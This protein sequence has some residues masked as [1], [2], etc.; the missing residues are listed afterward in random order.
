VPFS[1]SPHPSYA[2]INAVIHHP[3]DPA[4]AAAHM[5]RFL[6]LAPVMCIK[7]FMS[8]WFLGAP[9]AEVARGN[10]EDFVAYGFYQSTWAGLGAADAATA[11]RFVDDVERVWGIRYPGGRNDG[12][13]FMAHLWEP[14]RVVPKPLALHVAAEA[15]ALACAGVLWGMG[16][17]RRSVGG[18]GGGSFDYW[19]RP[20]GGRAKA[21][22]A[23]GD[24]AGVT[25]T[26]TPSPPSSPATP[27]RRALLSAP[28]APPPPSPPPAAPALAALAR[29]DSVTSLAGGRVYAAA[30]PAAPAAP[31]VTTAARPPRPIAFIHGV[32]L[33]IVPYL[34]LIWQV[35]A[36]HGHGRDV[37]LLEVPHVA[38]GAAPR[39]AAS[40][41]AVADAAVAMLAVEGHADACFAA[42]SYGTFC[43]S[44]ACQRHPGVVAS[45]LLIDPVC[46]L[47]C[48]PRLLYSFVYHAPGLAALCAGG[49][50]EVLGGVRYLFSRDLTIAETFCR[51]FLWHE[52]MLWPADMPAATLVALAHGDD[53][54]PSPLVARHLAA[55][56]P[57]AKVMYHPT[58]GHG[59]V[60][61]DWGWQ[62]ELVAEMGALL[63][64]PARRVEVGGA[65]AHAATKAA[66]AAAA[67]LP[68]PLPTMAATIPRRVSSTADDTAGENDAQPTTPAHHRRRQAGAHRRRPSALIG[69]SAGGAGEECGDC[70]LPL[71][72][73][74]S[75]TALPRRLFRRMAVKKADNSAEQEAAAARGRVRA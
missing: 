61:L 49:L 63:D 41:D 66:P 5:A 21:K 40:V 2:T 58:A 48:H 53:L 29:G 20:A 54:V 62:A 11:T 12:L 19:V 45:T 69:A 51:R 31:A 28:S 1:S 72:L 35:V 36:S 70:R 7:D 59:G 65:G 52:L 47:T 22:Q 9:F 46:L 24:A 32:G 55:S 25:A 16:F 73:G 10:V 42:H 8:G 27:R 13:S 37:L 30:A 17:R 3:A 26:P 75:S 15:G 38:L 56:A 23:G 18:G 39:R 33:G 34:G 44:R 68:L 50:R 74:P 57:G 6:E 60:L 64:V 43:V 71:T 14:L 67:P 4:A